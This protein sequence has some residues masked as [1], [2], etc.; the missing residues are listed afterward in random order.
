M[1]S[2]KAAAAIVLLSATSSLAA[3]EGYVLGIG[4]DGDTANGRAISAFGDFEVLDETWVS[5]A[6]GTAKVEGL[7]KDR[8]TRFVDAAIDHWFDPLGLRI[9]GGYWGD[10][11]LLDSRDLN[12]AIYLKGEAGSLS[13]HYERR[14][15]E[16]DLQS[17]QLR[18]R[19]ARFDADGWGLQGRL[20]VG[21]R[22]NIAAAGMTYD[23][24]RNLR[25]EQDIDV[26]RFLTVS[27]LSMIRSL[28][29][30][31]FSASI[32]FEFGLKSV[33]LTAGRWTTAVDGSRIDSYSIG[34][35]TPLTDRTDI[36]L[37]LAFDDSELFGE[38]TAL[39]VYL[40]YFGGS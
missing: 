30:D 6:G 39:S 7:L 19:T 35:L 29:D 11:E 16:F 32:E 38:T 36:E 14:R 5:L 4:V 24:S 17:D 15:F 22:I 23:Y 21:E 18:G 9:G 20:A 25:I 27:R 13:L 26:L 2:C 3:A 28:I 12:A 31:E 33:D 8:H 10:P 1:S 37:R 40:Y 34:F